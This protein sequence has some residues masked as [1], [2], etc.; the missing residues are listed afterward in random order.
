MTAQKQAQQ[1]HIRL[2]EQGMALQTQRR[3]PEAERCYQTVLAQ[4]PQNPDALHL[5]GLLAVE[6]DQF[7]VA[8]DYMEKAV[9]LLPKQ[10]IYRNN[11]GN[12]LLLRADPDG[13]LVHLRK[14]VKFAPRYV[15]AITNMGRAYRAC[16]KAEEAYKQFAKALAIDPDFERAEAGL[17]EMMLEIGDMEGAVKSFR[18]LLKRRPGNVQA[19]G[20]ISAAKVFGEDD[21]ELAQ[22]ETALNM[23]SLTPDQRVLLHHAAGKINNDLGRY[24]AAMKHYFAGKKTSG[25]QFPIEVHRKNYAAIK[26][27]LTKAGFGSYRTAGNPSQIPV[28][29]VGMPR[30]GTTLAEQI[31]ASHPMAAGAGE[32]AVMRKEGQRA[33]YGL[34][35]VAAYGRT[36]DALDQQQLGTIASS[37]LRTLT[38]GRSHALRCT[39]KNPQNY[40]QLGLIA[41]LFPNARIIHCRRDP[42]DTC[43]SNFMQSFDRS[44][45]YNANLT[46]LGAYFRCYSDLMDHWQAHLQLPIFDL[47]YENLIADQEGTTRSLINF[48]GLDW[49]DACLAYFDNARSV[50]TPSRWQVRQPI[51]KTSLKRWKRYEKHLGPLI[52]SLGDLAETE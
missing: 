17:A 35:D 23:Q 24:D 47:N 2:I 38:K 48:L 22:I 43:I 14:A 4:N 51:Y 32:L 33:G 26:A 1:R 6:A 12:V 44:H 15:E 45:G 49:D 21:P 5:M 19:L 42:L 8:V 11:L 50:T 18:A 10:A 3:F 30:S 13:A 9:R 16:G 31:I 40:E 36:V 7:S 37:Y 46:T 28:F 20:G 29:I 41:R 52:D 25:L 34:P 27:S 39:D